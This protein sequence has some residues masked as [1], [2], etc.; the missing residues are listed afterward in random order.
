MVE[1]RGHRRGQDLLLDRCDQRQ[2]G[3]ELDMPAAR[4][5]AIDGT[6]KRCLATFGSL[7]PL[8]ARLRRMPRKPSLC[9][10]SRSLSGVFSSITATPRA[11]APRARMPNWVAELSGPDTLG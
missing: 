5:H 3:V 8:V 4:L 2:C 7:T 9:M 1:H 10:A 11:V 6:R